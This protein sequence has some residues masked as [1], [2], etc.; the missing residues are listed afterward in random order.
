MSKKTPKGPTPSL[1]GS[2]NGKPT[3]VVAK[4]KSN[5][6][7]CNEDILMNLPCID[8]PQL[9]GAFVTQKRVCNECFKLI[10]DKTQADLD[11]LRRI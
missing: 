5:C 2:S 11:E 3:R 1:I 8:I 4:K 7:R 9:G 6:K 10:L